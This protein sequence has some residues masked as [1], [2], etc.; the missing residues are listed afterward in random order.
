MISIKLFPAASTHAALTIVQK[1]NH[2]NGMLELCRKRSMARNLMKIQKLF[3]DHYDFFP[4]TFTL[5]NDLTVG[6]ASSVLPQN[7]HTPK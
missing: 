3:P 4:K 2:F 7:V 6:M 1:I 5:P